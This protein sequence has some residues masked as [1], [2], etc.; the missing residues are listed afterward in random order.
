MREHG[1]NAADDVVLACERQRRDPRADALRDARAQQPERPE[2]CGDEE[3]RLDQAEDGDG[4][5]VAIARSFSLSRAAK[6][7]GISG[8]TA[9]NRNDRRGATGD[10]ALR[11]G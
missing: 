1:E 4:E 2:A 8:T 9:Q 7:R 11:A 10:P 6:R 3:R 5:E